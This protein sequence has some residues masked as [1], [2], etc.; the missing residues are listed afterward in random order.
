MQQEK[1]GFSENTARSNTY[2]IQESRSGIVSN[3]M[4]DTAVSPGPKRITIVKPRDGRWN[5]SLWTELFC[6]GK[7]GRS[8]PGLIP[9]H[10]SIYIGVSRIVLILVCERVRNVC[11]GIKIRGGDPPRE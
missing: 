3:C 5:K 2:G 9:G 11:K 8:K 10:L 7:S 6:I 1:E 4:R